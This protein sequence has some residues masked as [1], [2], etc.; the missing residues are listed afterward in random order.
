MTV[1]AEQLP[2]WADGLPAAAAALRTLLH[3][4]DSTTT[5]LWAGPG[6]EAAL[7]RYERIFLP[8]YAAYLAATGV[9]SLSG[10]PRAA[11]DA[12]VAAATASYNTTLK[13]ASVAALQQGRELDA[14]EKAAWAALRT[15]AG[16]VTAVAPIPPLDVAF[17]W[18]LARLDPAAYAADCVATFGTPLP[19]GGTLGGDAGAAAPPA[20]ANAVAHVWVGNAT[21]P[22]AVVARLQWVLFATAAQAAETPPPLLPGRL[23]KLLSCLHHRR[24][25]RRQHLHH[26]PGYLWPPV[27][28]TTAV[29]GFQGSS[30]VGVGLPKAAQVRKRWAPRA[31]VAALRSAAS[32]QRV[33]TARLG[34]SGFDDPQAL[35]L[36]A[37]RY[38]R[39]LGLAATP[40]GAATFLVPTT[41]MDLVWHAHL[42]ATAAY[43]EN[44]TALLGRVYAHMADD[45]ASPGGRL[46]DGRAATMALWTAAYP[47]H[48]YE[49]P[50]SLVVPCV[51]TAAAKATDMATGSAPSAAAAYRSGVRG[52]YWPQGAIPIAPVAAKV[53]LLEE[54]AA[55]A[56]ANATVSAGEA[57]TPKT[58]PDGLRTW[59]RTLAAATATAWRQRIGPAAVPGGG[60]PGLYAQGFVASAAD[61][62]DVVRSRAYGDPEV[63]R[64]SS[65]IAAMYMGVSAGAACGGGGGEGRHVTVGGDAAVGVGGGVAGVVAGVVGGG[66]TPFI[67][68]PP[69]PEQRERSPHCQGRVVRCSGGR[70]RGLLGR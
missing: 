20:S 49:P 16:G 69:V 30:G 35:R 24:L 22:A 5:P 41:D 4:V 36:A 2:P 7:L 29:T 54:V 43:R 1:D 28:G 32:S 31:R 50:P 39:F 18:A 58:S 21:E 46:A 66:E 17:V 15:N 56:S 23:G 26:L 52:G 27:A 9:I 65:G 19:V 60:W 61:P 55:E 8:M 11:A 70:T 44:T 33:F 63:A 51:A 3:R 48:P 10:A 40:A 34:A 67:S 45:D 38:V 42:M 64:G 53:A 12:L 57:A 14:D 62:V 59:D 6:L 25:L 37:E 68:S 47:A 13:A